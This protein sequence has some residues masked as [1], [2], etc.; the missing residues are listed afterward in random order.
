M[1]LGAGAS[2]S[3]ELSDEEDSESLFAFLA[4]AGAGAV[5]LGSA[6]AFLTGFSSSE[7]EESEDESLLLEDDDEDEAAFFCFFAGGAATSFFAEEPETT[8]LVVTTG[9]G[10]SS[11]ELLEL[12]LDDESE[13]GAFLAISFERG[14]ERE[15]KGDGSVSVSTSSSHGQPPQITL[16]TC[17]TVRI[18]QTFGALEDFFAHL[19][20]RS[21]GGWVCY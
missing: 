4:G 16:G 15:T 14:V 9:I 5:F 17:C 8:F 1:A 11:S 19:G 20:C 3:E 7:E 21:E 12:S 13:T 18:K 10:V 6:A 2:S